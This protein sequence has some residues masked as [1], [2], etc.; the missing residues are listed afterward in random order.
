MLVT[1]TAI[2]MTLIMAQTM[3]T[4]AAAIAADS[5]HHSKRKA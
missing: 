3:L 4:N 5:F 2:R 1:P